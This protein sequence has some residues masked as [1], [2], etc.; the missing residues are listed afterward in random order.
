VLPEMA[1]TPRRQPRM[2]RRLA[3]PGGPPADLG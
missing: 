3:A 2:G 1:M